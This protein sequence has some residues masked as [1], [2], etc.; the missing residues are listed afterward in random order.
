MLNVFCGNVVV[1]CQFRFISSCN[2]TIA[3]MAQLRRAQE[4]LDL[5]KQELE[6]GTGMSLACQMALVRRRFTPGQ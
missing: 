3:N 2:L 4:E 6:H 1:I 5:L